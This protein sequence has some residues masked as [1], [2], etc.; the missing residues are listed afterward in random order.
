MPGRAHDRGA[1]GATRSRTARPPGLPR[2]ARRRLAARSPGRRRRGRVDELAHGLLALGVGKGD[3]VAIL[4]DGR[5][6][7]WALFD[8][9]LASIGAIGVPI[10]PTSS[11]ARVPP[12][13]SSTPTR[14]ASLCEDDE[15]R[16]KVDAQ[17]SS[18]PHAR[19][20]HRRSPTST[21]CEERGRAL[22]TPSTRTPSTTRAAAVGEDDLFTFIYT[23]GTTG[24]PKGC[25]IRHRNYFEM[26]ADA[27]TSSSDFVERGR[28]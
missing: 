19:A 3:A 11:R 28:R 16:A 12:T 27:S 7:E 21:R 14:S 18:L 24:P 15:Q 22:R 17:R 20:R 25:M 13:S 26:V 5:A 8:F 2:R 1:S 4:G 6:L 9:A 10:Y 23:S